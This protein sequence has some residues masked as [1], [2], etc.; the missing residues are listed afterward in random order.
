MVMQNRSQFKLTTQFGVTDRLH[1]KPHGGTDL[2]GEHGSAI[3]STGDGIVT[4]V[5]PDPNGYGNRIN[6][7]H[8]RNDRHPYHDGNE[9]VYGHLAESPKLK[10]GDRVKRG[11]LIGRLGNTGRSSGPHLHYE[12]RHGRTGVPLLHS[13]EEAASALGEGHWITIDGHHIFIK[14]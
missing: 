3:L 5:S 6:I 9:R 7:R 11:D 8:D 13:K 4:R 10:T 2:A 1:K 12:V 14:D